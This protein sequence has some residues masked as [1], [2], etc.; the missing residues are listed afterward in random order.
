MGPVEELKTRRVELKVSEA[1]ACGTQNS[2]LRVI[3]HR[4][5]KVLN[6]LD[7]LPSEKLQINFI[8]APFTRSRVARMMS[9]R[10]SN[11][12]LEKRRTSMRTCLFLTFLA[13]VLHAQGGRICT[14]RTIQGS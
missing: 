9:V 2:S 11:S 13:G 6:W 5:A 4:L 3:L 14:D 8:T 7:V 1:P 10:V 12:L